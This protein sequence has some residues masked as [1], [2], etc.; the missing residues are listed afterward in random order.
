MTCLYGA[1]MKTADEE[2]HIEVIG[3]SQPFPFSDG[4]EVAELIIYFADIFLLREGVL[5]SAM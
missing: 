3:T 5:E 1:H 2:L 4:E